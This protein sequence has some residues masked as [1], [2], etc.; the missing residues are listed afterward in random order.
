MLQSLAI[1]VLTMLLSIGA[2]IQSRADARSD[3]NLISLAHRFVADYQALKLVEPGPSYAN[4]F[5]SI[6]SIPGIEKQADVF[7]RYEALLGAIEATGLSAEPRQILARLRYQVDFELERTRL[8]LRYRQESRG[9]ATPIPDDGLFRLAHHDEWYRFF[10]RKLAGRVITPD[11]ISDLGQREV[12]R[13]RYEMSRIQSELG[14]AGKDEAFYAHLE[15]PSFFYESEDEVQSA[16]EALRSRVFASLGQV[17]DA[18]AI[19]PVQIRPAPMPNKDTPP[20]YYDDGTFYFNFY[21]GHYNRRAL[22]WCFIH[23]AVP[24][25]HYEKTL[26]RLASPVPELDDLFWYAGYTEGWGAYSEN[27][28]AE[29]GLMDDPYLLYGWHEWNLVRSARLVLDVGIHSRGWSKSEALAYWRANVPHQDGIAEREIDRVIRWPGQVISYKVGEAAILELR[30]RMEKLEG[31]S[32]DLRHFHSRLLEHGVV[33]LSV[34]PGI[35][36]CLPEHNAVR[37]YASCTSA[38]TNS[39]DSSNS[40]LIEK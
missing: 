12:A 25:H 18:R 32:F 21:G 24:G 9:R 17:V 7:N 5:K 13:I 19:H 39:H 8:E 1:A 20:A 27:L 3:E 2:P 26:K 11:E 35:M 6:G 28:G 22:H 29:L 38:W 34:L 15:D 33:P 4:Y 31:R 30:Q 16:Y 37:P 14:Y 23:E 36:G 40:S 10:A